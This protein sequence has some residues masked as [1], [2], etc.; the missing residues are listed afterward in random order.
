MKAK[1]G[2]YLP[3]K[4]LNYFCVLIVFTP[5]QG[6]ERNSAQKRCHSGQY[7]Q[8]KLD[9]CWTRLQYHLWMSCC[10]SVISM[11]CHP[12]QL[13]AKYHANH[14]PYNSITLVHSFTH[15]CGAFTSS[16]IILKQW[17]RLF[18]ARKHC[19]SVG[20]CD[21]VVECFYLYQCCAL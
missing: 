4:Q 5:N 8:T 7:Y 12:D 18:V 6:R 10:L 2:Y 14:C 17:E 13:M 3:V 21:G 15:N 1:Y 9:R 11:Q 19:V 20:V 16:T